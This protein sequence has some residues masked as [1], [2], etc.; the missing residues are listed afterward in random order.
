MSEIDVKDLPVE[1]L[2]KRV[3]NLEKENEQLRRWWQE[4]RE[5]ARKAAEKLEVIKSL[6]NLL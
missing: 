2:R 5:E 3:E 4:A 6:L 1:E